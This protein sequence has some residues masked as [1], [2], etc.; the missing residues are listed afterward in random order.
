[1]HSM[2][3]DAQRE[4]AEHR[5][6]PLLVFA[7]TILTVTESAVLFFTQTA[8]D[9]TLYT[10]VA[11]VLKTKAVPLPDKI[12]AEAA[13]VLEVHAPAPIE[14]T[15]TSAAAGDASTSSSA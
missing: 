10:P 13:V 14:S 2:L 7:A 15:A 6:S 11:G 8:T 3:N 4:V 1:M 9:V 5:G 12:C